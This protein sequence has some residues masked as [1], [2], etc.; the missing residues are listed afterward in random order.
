MFFCV[1]PIFQTQDI[2]GI[3]DQ[4]GR[5]LAGSQAAA[6]TIC[7]HIVLALQVSDIPWERPAGRR[8][9][10]LKLRDSCKGTQVAQSRLLRQN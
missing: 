5:L 10:C 9:L 2:G 4:Q 6:I 8:K 1:F 3:V 7:I